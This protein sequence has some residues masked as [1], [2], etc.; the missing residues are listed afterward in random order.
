MHY[1]IKL[2][3]LIIVIM[4]ITVSCN[5]GP[6]S[7]NS[8]PEYSKIKK[9]SE[10]SS[11][12]PHIHQEINSSENLSEDLHTVVV[13]EILTATRYL[14][15][16]VSEGNEQFWIAVRK[17]EVNVGETYYYKRALLKTNFES[18]ENNKVFEKIYLVTKLVSANHGN[19]QETK[20]N[21]IDISEV[22]DVNKS[23]AEKVES[24]KSIVT[25]EGSVKIAE[26]VENIS[27]YEGKTVQVSGKCVKINP[28]IMNRNWIH[29]KDGSKDDYD[30]VITSDTFVAEG[31]MITMKALV[32]V[33][34]DFGAGYKYDLI[35]ENG[36]LVTN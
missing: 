1:K 4:L 20:I 12:N 11:K 33:N 2:P 26:L 6:E 27:K 15:L 7:V 5:S 24:S 16:N 18:K 8:G 22:T 3:V 31:T 23:K 25:V 17:Q 32:S 21:N 28:G 29:I 36:V 35:L 34:K 30:L 10:Q 14:Y 9:D 19:E 13:N